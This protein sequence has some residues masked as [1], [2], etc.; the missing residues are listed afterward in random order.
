MVFPLIAASFL[1]A[2]VGGGLYAASVSSIPAD[3]GASVGEVVDELNPIPDEEDFGVLLKA[4]AL[5]GIGV[6]GVILAAMWLLATVAKTGA[7]ER[8]AFRA[9]DFLDN[10]VNWDFANENLANA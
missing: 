7:P 8:G 10:L 4:F 5:W 3:I 2:A 1:A 6:F 9:L